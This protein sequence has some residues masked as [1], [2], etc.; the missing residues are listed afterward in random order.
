MSKHA[1][2]IKP[3]DD[4]AF[5]LPAK[6]SALSVPLCAGGLL[7]L[8]GGW[9]LGTFG[10]SNEF[11][12]SAYLT[13][14]IYCLT[15]ALGA[16]FFVLIQHLCRAG[17]SVV[18]RRV[19]ELIMIMLVPLAFL[20]IPILAT[21]WIGEGTIYKWD[22]PGFAEH[23]HLSPETWDNKLMYLNPEFFTVRSAVYLLI[24]V[25]LAVYFFR[26]SVRQDET[27]EI[28]A[29]E[30]MQKWS[31]PALMLL[32]LSMSFAMFDWVMTLAP[33]W[34]STMFGVYMFAGGILAAH[35][36]IAAGTF[37]LQKT[38]ALRDEVTVEHYHDLGKYIFGFVFFWAY[39]GFSQYLLIWY[40]NIPEETVWLFD[41]QIGV[42]AWVS[43]A[44][45]FFHWILPFIS[46]MSRHV[47]RRPPLVF[48]WAVYILILHYVD[49]YWC[50]M[51][52]LFTGA[53]GAM[54]AVG[55]AIGIF[56]SILMAV[57]MATLMLGMMLRVAGQTRVAASRDPR[58]RESLAFE[59]I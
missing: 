7:V 12:M 6:L 30:R 45:V 54:Q 35:C 20:F 14:F 16:T 59:N 37:V 46:T 28:K 23:H 10:V 52:E 41:R 43:L 15:I 21:L 18:V 56:A 17:W 31:A 57:G 11:G 13:A 49:I 1:P 44:L 50:V 19:A 38:G 4:P 32:S 55:G 26:S 5:Q 39:I 25:G 2:A 53:D 58:F 33:M 47:R 24:W 29:T 48:G 42:W 9:A 8:I 51:P 36:A 3:A 40:A 27:G 34:F 22:D